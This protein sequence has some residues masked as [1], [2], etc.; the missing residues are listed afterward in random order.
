[1][2]APCAKAQHDHP[3]TVVHQN[4]TG[5]CD[6]HCESPR[7]SLQL[8]Y[9]NA[10]RDNS[11]LKQTH[12]P[13]RQVCMAQHTVSTYRRTKEIVNDADGSTILRNGSGYA[14]VSDSE[15]RDPD[16]KG[17]A[18]VF[19]TTE[20]RVAN[21]RI[22]EYAKLPREE[23][24]KTLLEAIEGV[25]QS[26]NHTAV[27]GEIPK[28]LTVLLAKLTMNNGDDSDGNG[29][30]ERTSGSTNTTHVHPPSGA[31][32]AEL[33]DDGD[34]KQIA[35]YHGMSGSTETQDVK[36]WPHSE[37]NT[38]SLQETPNTGSNNAFVPKYSEGVDGGTANGA[39]SGSSMHIFQGGRHLI[40]DSVKAE[41]QDHRE[42]RTVAN[43]IDLDES[44]STAESP[45][46]SGDRQ[47][48]S[49]VEE[50]KWFP[51]VAPN[52]PI[53]DESTATQDRGYEHVHRDNKNGKRV[54][55]ITNK[56]VL[57]IAEFALHNLP[58]GENS[59]TQGN[60]TLQEDKHAEGN[61][62]PNHGTTK[63]SL[64]S[65]LGIFSGDASQDHQAKEDARLTKKEYTVALC[66][67]IE[68]A[69]KFGPK[70]SVT[71]TPMESRESIARSLAKLGG[72]TADARVT[73]TP[74]VTSTLTPV[75]TMGSAIM[76]RER[77]G[78]EAGLVKVEEDFENDTLSDDLAGTDG[79]RT[80]QEN[81]QVDAGVRNTMK[82]R[83]RLGTNYACTEEDTPG[84]VALKEDSGDIGT[85][86]N[87]QAR[88][89]ATGADA[90]YS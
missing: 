4:H 61:N 60:T 22:Q 11:E 15:D 73:S 18:R 7:N 58:D 69:I 27:K 47:V 68:T 10:L 80:G 89:Q 87:A 33:G 54:T 78:R 36:Q 81:M 42:A 28:P 55:P 16:E 3:I 67:A 82:T 62:L 72:Y 37:T 76:E 59:A 85:D 32:A 90:M 57:K 9:Y 75:N 83:N 74:R 53:A 86:K 63:K 77:T 21:A 56:G 40:P 12:E 6:I 52:S 5:G 39:G 35:D 1:M 8:R 38:M 2:Q 13:S 84:A 45:C 43:G 51:Q 20:D 50:E 14:E 23:Y 65:M 46:Q 41:K 44:Q 70:P 34:G 19:C 24:R 66:Q 30:Q 71:L 48:A 88:A 17:I 31:T 49:G 29:H 64:T 25:L 26:R 79:T